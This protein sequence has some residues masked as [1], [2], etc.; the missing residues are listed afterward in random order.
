MNKYL[1]GV[2]LICSLLWGML[3]WI[4]LGLPIQLCLFLDRITFYTFSSSIH[5]IANGFYYDVNNNEMPTIIFLC[6]YLINF[7]LYFLLLLKLQEHKTQKYSLTIIILF[8]IVFRI[9]LIP[10]QLIHEND[11]YRYLWDGKTFLNGINPYKFS[12]SDVFLHEHGIKE[13]YWDQEYNVFYKVRSFS[14]REE[15]K[16]NKLIELKNQNLDFYQRIGHRQVPT[17]YPPLA[18]IFFAFCVWL[19]KDSI[20]LMKSVFAILDIC[21]IVVLIEILKLV[22]LNPCNCLVYGWS[23][24]VLKEIP[25]SG[26]YDSLAILLMCLSLYFYLK[27]DH[28][29][30]SLMLAL[31]ALSKIF[32]LGLLPILGRELKRRE[33]M[34]LGGI[35][36]LFYLPFIL[37]DN[38]GIR[39]VWEGLIIYNR[40]WFYNSSIF[41]L[42][43]ASFKQFFPLLA[44][45]L[46]TAK[47]LVG[48][49]Y[50]GVL[51]LLWKDLGRSDREILH[52]CF[53][54]VAS[55]FLLSPVGDPWY[56]CWVI[57]FLCVF[58]YR[59]WIILSALLILS[60]LN[61][62]SDIMMTTARFFHIPLINWVIYLPFFFIYWIVDRKRTCMTVRNQI[63]KLL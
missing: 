30:V 60:Y 61:F 57:P 12:P 3:S 43:Y 46:L 13:D 40:N 24:L 56:Y 36:L 6:L 10:S 18:Q 26:H 34:V 23:P 4:S 1:L 37:T 16:L 27:K 59:S 35:L 58:P 14:E 33:W 29:G 54:A 45:S 42:I 31:A 39:R 47:V 38:T 9:I 17:I 48:L 50:L 11:I 55:L 28:W 41:A 15:Q 5:R 7:I 25:N 22:K 52:K 49:I 21:V 20:L 8:S 51:F 62:R 53:M 32:T 2:G 44:Q 19:K 63:M